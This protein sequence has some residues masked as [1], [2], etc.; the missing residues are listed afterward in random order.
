MGLLLG[1]RDGFV[2]MFYPSYPTAYYEELGI[3]LDTESKA[4]LLEVQGQ[5]ASV[6]KEIFYEA[7]ADVHLIDPNTL[8]F[9]SRNRSNQRHA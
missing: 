2:S 4:R 7:N 6:D 1:Q 9:Y 3:N 5:Q 8:Q